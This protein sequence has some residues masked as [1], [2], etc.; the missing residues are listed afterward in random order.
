MKIKFFGHLIKLIKLPLYFFSPVKQYNFDCKN[1]E[2]ETGLTL[3]KSA[4]KQPENQFSR[5]PLSGAR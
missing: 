3:R 5:I 2:R 4:E 1:L